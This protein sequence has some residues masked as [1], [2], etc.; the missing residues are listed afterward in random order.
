[1][2]L[3]AIVTAPTADQVGA[4]VAA[5]T[6]SATDLAAEIED[7][8]LYCRSQGVKPSTIKHSYGYSLRAVLLPWCQ[9]EGITR[10]AGIDQGAL[11]R[12]AANLGSRTTRAGT[13]LSHATT[14]TY[15]KAANQLLRWYANEHETTAPNLRL[16]QP[17]G[18]TVNTLGRD[19][20]GV[21]ERTAATERDRVI[22]RLLADTGMRPAEL[23]SITKRALRQK[24]TRHYVS[25][26]EKAGER[27]VPIT[28]HM[29]DRLLVLARGGDADPVFVGLRRDRR[30]G[31]RHPL[32]VPGLRQMIA[33]LAL[34]AG[35]R[36]AVNPYVLRQSACRWLLMSGQS[37]VMVEHILGS[38]S[39]A[40][41]RQHYNDLGNDDAHDRLM[42]VLRKE[43]SR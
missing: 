33:A 41:V 22:V 34:D 30:T 29:F 32:T 26:R 19:Q 6:S 25:V 42:F 27:D 13:P 28:T 35:I 43:R 23:V 24:D 2:A 14:W 3:V 12:F 31:E 17:A 10:V 40:M 36:T 21:M 7:Y 18:R 5:V 20:I 38:G 16:H 15:K 1:V 4:R 37:P 11:D 39:E 8:L 9:Y